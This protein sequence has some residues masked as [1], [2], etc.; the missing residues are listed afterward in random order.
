[1]A[2]TP[3]VVDGLRQPDDRMSILQPD[4]Y[5]GA[6]AAKTGTEVPV[7]IAERIAKSGAAVEGRE[8]YRYRSKFANHTI[9][10]FAEPDQVLP[11]GRIVRGKVM[12]AKFKDGYW[13][14]RNDFRFANGDPVS[15]EKQREWIESSQNFSREPGIGDFWDADLQE[16]VNARSIYTSFVEAVQSDPKLVEMLKRDL[17][18]QD[19]DIVAALASKPRPATDEEPAG[20]LVEG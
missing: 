15:H 2:R 7:G 13:E 18:A 9:L 3:I 5:R 14:T 10:M 4:P 12:Q 19:F 20:D 8:K 6:P 11:G 17:A 16:H 1:M